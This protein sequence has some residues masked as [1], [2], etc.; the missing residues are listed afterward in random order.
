MNA[1]G[2][3][4][5]VIGH[6]IE[7]GRAVVPCAGSEREASVRT[8]KPPPRFP[9]FQANAVA[10][11]TARRRFGS[12]AGDDAIVPVICPT[13]Q[14]VFR[15]QNIHAGDPMLLC[16]GL[17]SIFLFCDVTATAVTCEAQAGST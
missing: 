16:M 3:P 10:R 6:A 1:L 2:A 4:A 11:N 15:G 17:F 5:V 12:R 9:P 14:N 13:C 8:P 7:R